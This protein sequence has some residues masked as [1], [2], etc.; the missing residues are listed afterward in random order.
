MLS[1]CLVAGATKKDLDDT[2]AVHPTLSEELVLFRKPDETVTGENPSPD[3]KMNVP[4]PNG[5]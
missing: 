4:H 1:A 2:V 5:D 3:P